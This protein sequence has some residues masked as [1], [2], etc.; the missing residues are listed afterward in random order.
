MCPDAGGKQ[1]RLFVAIVT[2][3]YP[4]E[5]NGVARTVAMLAGHLRGRGH[6]IEVVRPRQ[7][8]RDH[9][10]TGERMGELLLP[11][12]RLTRFSGVRIGLPARRRLLARWRAARPDVVHVVTEGPLGWSAAAAARRLGIPMSTGFHTNFHAY[13]RHYGLRLASSLATRY[14]RTFHNRADCTLVPTDDTRDRLA[15]AGFER[16]RIVGRGVDRSLFHPGRRSAR[17]RRQWGCPGEET[18]V[19][20]VGRLAPEKNLGLF[21]EAALAIRRADPAARVVLVGDGPEAGALRA[22]HPGFVYAGLRTGGDLAAHYASADLL[23]FPSLT[24]T[25]GNVVTEGLASGLAVVAYDYAAAHAHIRHGENGLLARYGDDRELVALAVTGAT[26]PS[27]RARLRE[28]AARATAA[29]SWDR[30]CD[31][32]EEVLLGLASRPRR[33]PARAV[34]VP[35]QGPTV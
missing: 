29:L 25:F 20:Y 5:V 2:E 33:D 3:T 17:L 21:V 23:V 14:L 28:N 8:P 9:P 22:S 11:A 1:A 27:L 34:G 30:A 24:E 7:G 16:L 13:S 4:P 6:R 26:D 12:V 31:E 18:V 35:T 10:A 19:G 15:A 32:L